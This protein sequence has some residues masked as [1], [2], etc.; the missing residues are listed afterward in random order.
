MPAG[1][2]AQLLK[3][4]AGLCAIATS[5]SEAAASGLAAAAEVPDGQRADSE[6]ALAAVVRLI[7][8]EHAADTCERESRRRCLLAV[9]T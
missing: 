6:D 8:A 3:A 4:L 5:A 7:D 9:S 1:V 2:A